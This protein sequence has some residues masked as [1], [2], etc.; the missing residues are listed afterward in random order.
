MILC[1]S[2]LT[3]MGWCS[4]TAW[5]SNKVAHPL[6]IGWFC[7]LTKSVTFIRNCWNLSPSLFLRISMYST[8]REITINRWAATLVDFVSLNIFMIFDLVTYLVISPGLSFNNRSSSGIFSINESILPKISLD[9]FSSKYSMTPPKPPDFHS[10]CNLFLIC[11]V[12]FGIYCRTSL[13]SLY[14]SLSR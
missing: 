3:L 10:I 1:G 11:S 4:S 5:A 7:R 2:T 13:Q 12:S 9:R 6:I 8:R 14:C